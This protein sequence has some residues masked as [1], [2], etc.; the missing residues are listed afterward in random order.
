M[1][2]SIFIQIASYRDPELI[3][4]IRDCINNAEHPERLVFSI[5]R[6]FYY[7]DTWDNVDEFR[8]DERFKFIDIPALESKG[9]CWAR[10]LLQQNYDGEDYTLQLDSHHRFVEGWDSKLIKMHTDLVNNGYPKPLITAYVNP[11]N[12][13]T[14]LNKNVNPQ[15][16]RFKEFSRD[17]FLLNVPEVIQENLDSPVRARYYSAHFAFAKGDFV[18]EVPHDPEMYF[19]GEEISIAARAFTWG[20][21]LFHPHI[22]IAF[23]EYTRKYRSKHWDDHEEWWKLNLKSINRYKELFDI[24]STKIHHTKYGFGPHRTLKEYCNFSG[25]SFKYKKIQ[26]YTHENR[27]PPNPHTNEPEERWSGNLKK[28]K[29]IVEIN[30]EFF[31]NE[32][33][34]MC[35][36]IFIAQDNTDLF[37]EDIT[38]KLIITHAN[39]TPHI[40]IEKGFYSDKAP[41]HWVLWLFSNENG[42]QSKKTGTLV[43]HDKNQNLFTFRDQT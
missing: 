40:K 14:D 23:H 4:T 16:M 39:S 1:K 38:H 3:P 37:R 18:L 6:Q 10:N 22:P 30:K 27:E 2:N 17:G 34:D 42:W 29:A 24:D 9:T 7:E 19:T 33:Y 15:R 8:T 12:P 35:A 21:D 31:L 32:D 26:K 13:E 11:Y 5:T 43:Q 28:Y 25:I 20:Y 41:Y 36:V